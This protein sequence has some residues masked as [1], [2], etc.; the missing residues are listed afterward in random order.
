[1][2]LGTGE[3]LFIILVVAAMTFF[4]RLVPFLFFDNNK[5]TPKVIL[6]L[7]QALPYGIMVLLVVYC[8][9]GIGFSAP[10]LWLPEVISVAVVILL[11][12]W[13][14]NNLLSIISGTALYMVLIQFVFVRA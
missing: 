4:A 2:R 11:H 6:Y 7:G 5:P 9:K 8:L 1:M 13:K 3:S 14:K 10:S 12:V